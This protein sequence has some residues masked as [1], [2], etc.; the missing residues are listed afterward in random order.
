MRMEV[1]GYDAA[2]SQREVAHAMG[3]RVVG[4]EEV[5]RNADFLSLNCSLTTSNRYMIGEREFWIMKPGAYIINTAR[6][7]LLDEAALVR[8]LANGRIAGAALDVFEEEPL[9]LNSPLRQ[10]EQCILGAHNSSNTSEAVLRVNDL[11]V[12]NLLDGLGGT[13]L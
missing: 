2:D 11:A 10:F 5:L 1:M 6:G 8:T 4:F 7:Q 3:V 13:F 9:P 12:R